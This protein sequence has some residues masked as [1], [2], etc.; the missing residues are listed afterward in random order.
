M[1]IHSKCT[2]GFTITNIANIFPRNEN[3]RIKEGDTGLAVALRHLIGC[4]WYSIKC[5]QTPTIESKYEKTSAMKTNLE[6]NL[7]LGPSCS[8]NLR[9]G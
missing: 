1:L 8:G 2:I 7:F 5:N 9:E 4:L 3:G 6:I